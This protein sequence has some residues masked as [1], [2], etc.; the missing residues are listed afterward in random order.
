MKLNLP[1]FLKTKKFQIDQHIGTGQHQAEMK[2]TENGPKQQ[3]LLNCLQNNETV[4]NFNDDLC[5]IMVSCNIPLNNLDVPEFKT[6]LEK[7]TKEKVVS[8]RT[9]SRTLIPK[10]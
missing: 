10:L 9:A 3:L 8:R 5:R 7:Y 2:K 1:I 6:F 4:N